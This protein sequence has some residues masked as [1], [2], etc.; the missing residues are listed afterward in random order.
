MADCCLNLL[1]P[2]VAEERVL[3]ALLAIGEA[4]VFMSAPASAHGF[5][6]GRLSTEEQVSGRS[7]AV[8]VQVL[9]PFDGLDALL[10]LLEP[11]LA[12]TGVRYWVT[13][14]ARQGEFQ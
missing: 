11:E 8:L 1:S 3:D 7:G 14:V 10:S 12:R 4:G 5:A 9:L 13:P 6:H 2:V